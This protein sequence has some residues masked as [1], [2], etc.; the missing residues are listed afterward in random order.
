MEELLLDTIETED[1]MA[2]ILDFEDMDI[3]GADP[4]HNN[5]DEFQAQEDD[6]DGFELDF[7]E[8]A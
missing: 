5:A 1:P 8:T 3:L 2:D 4:V 6:I 7:A